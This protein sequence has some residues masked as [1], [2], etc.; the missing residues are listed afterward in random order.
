MNA[1]NFII[2]QKASQYRWSGDCFLSIKSFY[3]GSAKYRVQQREY[4]VNENNYLILNDYTKYNLTI[5]NISPIESFCVFF[6]PEFVCQIVSELNSSEEQLLDF[7]V[8]RTESIKL[9]ERNYLHRGDVSKILFQGRQSSINTLSEIEKK[10][11]YHSLLNAIL[12]QNDDSLK[13]SNKLPSKKKSTR[14][15]IYRRVLYAKDYIDCNYSENLTLKTIAQVAMLSENHL[16]RNFSQIFDISPFQ[17]ITL[18]KIAEAKRLIIE[19]DKSVTEIAI[20]LGYSSLSNFSYYFKNV[21][22]QSPAV[23]RKKGDA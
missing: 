16:L 3:N 23:L 7:S 6:T 18:L 22:G 12:F 10:E 13:Q 4:T 20:S 1:N 9:L 14:E 11:F 21:V 19:T 8:K 5:D 15:E 17:Y 2:H